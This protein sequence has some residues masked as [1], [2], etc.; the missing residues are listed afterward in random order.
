MTTKVKTLYFSSFNMPTMCAA[1][2]SPSGY[3]KGLKVS[4]SKS[5]W[6]GKETATLTVELPLCEECAKVNVVSGT[7][8]F[9][10]ALGF[11]G[12]IAACLLIAGLNATDTIK[13]PL[14]SIVSGAVLITAIIIG[15]NKLVN[16]VD[17]KGFTPE[18]R[19]RRKKVQKCAKIQSF[20]LPGV[21][22]N[23][24]FVVFEF[25]DPLFAMEF[26]TLNMG[27]IV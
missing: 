11:I 4:S 2:H 24:S 7:G 13:N 23:Q 15:T 27:T 19:E 8:K 9:L 14:V 10:K 22:D 25:Q 6:S 17:M 1:C 3:G 20:K 16:E 12:V 18:Q 26:S 5:N 21:F